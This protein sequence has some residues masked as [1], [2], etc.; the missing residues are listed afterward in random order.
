MSIPPQLIGKSFFCVKAGMLCGLHLKSATTVAASVT[1][2]PLHVALGTFRLSQLAEL[3]NASASHLP[4]IVSNIAAAFESGNG[5]DVIDP[6]DP[7][8]SAYEQSVMLGAPRNGAAPQEPVAPAS[9]LRVRFVVF[10]TEYDLT[11]KV[12]RCPPDSKDPFV[13]TLVMDLYRAALRARLQQA[14]PRA[15]TADQHVDTGDAAAAAPSVPKVSPRGLPPR[16]GSAPWRGVNTS[17]A[18]Q[19]ASWESDQD[20]R[21]NPRPVGPVTNTGSAATARLQLQNELLAARHEISRL[22]KALAVSA[23]TA[24]HGASEPSGPLIQQAPK[25]PKLRPHTGGSKMVS[26]RRMEPATIPRVEF[27][28]ASLA[29]L[30]DETPRPRFDELKLFE[31]FNLRR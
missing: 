20:E 31:T 24:E 21:P 25:P 1:Q 9:A 13:W 15:A 10:A 2:E 26:G 6:A 4:T 18:K 30:D 22:Q 12:K 14:S 7:T 23:V 19:L 29:N 27:G 3:T 17:R 11:L 8:L 5:V 16:V 28:A